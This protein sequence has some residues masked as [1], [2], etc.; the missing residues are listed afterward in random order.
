MGVV[1]NP[2]SEELLVAEKGEGAYLNGKRIAVSKTKD[3]NKSVLATGF[4]YYIREKP[5]LIFEYFKEFRL[6]AQ[7]IRRCGSAAIDLC[8]VACGRLNGFWEEGLKPWDMA[9][10]SLIVK[11]A[12]GSLSQF[13]GSLFDIYTPE[14]VAN[15]GKIHQEMLK[16]IKEKTMQA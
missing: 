1:Y 7:G 6:A 11:E 5:G 10:G 16:I 3:L 4:P 2:S 8:N 15:N 14:I 12:G 9:A 13:D